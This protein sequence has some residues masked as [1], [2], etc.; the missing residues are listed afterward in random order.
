[1]KHFKNMMKSKLGQNV[2]CGFHNEKLLP[3]LKPLGK[4]LQN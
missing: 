3:D 1:M 2:T 4:N